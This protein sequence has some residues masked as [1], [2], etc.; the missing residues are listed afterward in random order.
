MGSPYPGVVHVKPMAELRCHL[1][2]WSQGP[3][4]GLGGTQPGAWSGS[5]M[6]REGLELSV[7]L[8]SGETGEKQPCHP[9]GACS[10]ALVNLGVDG[11]Y[12]SFF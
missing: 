7:W 6:K 1:I 2:S 8:G 9:P 11:K 5:G 10:V 3:G 4:G 12:V